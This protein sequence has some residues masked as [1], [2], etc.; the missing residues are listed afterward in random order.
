MVYIRPVVRFFQTKPTASLCIETATV[1]SHQHGIFITLN[2]G[3]RLVYDNLVLCGKSTSASN[4]TTA[5]M[6]KTVSLSSDLLRWMDIA[7]KLA[8]IPQWWNLTTLMRTS[9]NYTSEEPQV[10]QE[11]SENYTKMISIRLNHAL[12]EPEMTHSYII[13]ETTTMQK[14]KYPMNKN[15]WKYPS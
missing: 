15:D 6:C 7:W 14:L 8:K 12:T 10:W 4:K 11:S 3:L 5:P 1:W 9:F 13:N 2:N